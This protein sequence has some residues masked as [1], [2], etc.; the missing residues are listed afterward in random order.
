[1]PLPTCQMN[2]IICFFFFFAQH[3]VLMVHP[4]V[5]CPCEVLLS[6]R[7]RIHSDGHTTVYS[8]S[9]EHL[10]FFPASSYQE[11]CFELWSKSINGQLGDE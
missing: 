6:L 5:T 3:T 10:G 1:M 8:C 9:D 7:N 11:E 4:A 2:G